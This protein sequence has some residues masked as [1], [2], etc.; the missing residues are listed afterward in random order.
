MDRSRKCINN[1]KKHRKCI[2]VIGLS[3]KEEEEEE[4]EEEVATNTTKEYNLHR[5]HENKNITIL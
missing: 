2:I 5:K 3:K 1:W 4:E